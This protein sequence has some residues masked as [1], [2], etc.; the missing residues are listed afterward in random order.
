MIN[1]RSV[2]GGWFRRALRPRLASR[3]RRT[4]SRLVAEVTTLEGRE[5]LA[6][7]GVQMPLAPPGSPGTYNTVSSLGAVLFTGNATV[8][9]VPVKQ[10]TLYNN[11]K[12]TI[13][14]FLYDPNTGQST[15]GGYYDPF[16]AH[17]Q[18]YRAYI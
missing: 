17:G 4:T 18:Q 5:L 8:G 15:T 6:T 2:A 7:A 14:P 16:D 3:E 12:H 9:N 13:Y 11:T 10:I 1:P